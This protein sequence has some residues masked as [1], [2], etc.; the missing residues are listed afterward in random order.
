MRAPELIRSIK[1]HNKENRLNNS[2]YLTII[3]KQEVIVMIVDTDTLISITEANQNCSKVT[4]RV[5]EK[6][7]AVIMK[8]NA[9][10]YIVI[11]FS[12]LENSNKVASE[13]ATSLAKKLVTDKK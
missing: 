3:F 5:D 7:A 2:Y 10:K 9:P 1:L 12:R 8:N 13:A 6:G 11:E 4:R